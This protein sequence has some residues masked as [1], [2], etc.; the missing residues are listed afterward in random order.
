MSTLSVNAQVSLPRSFLLNR[1]QS[2][3]FSNR[4]MRELLVLR[5]RLEIMVLREMLVLPE[6]LDLLVPPDL[7][8]VFYIQLCRTY[9]YMHWFCHVE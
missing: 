1:S 9:G 8:F 5:E 2:F 3:C 7:R 6:L 4:V